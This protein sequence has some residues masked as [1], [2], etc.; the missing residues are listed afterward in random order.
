MAISVR[1]LIE[2]HR[3]N[4]C[5]TFDSL[6]TPFFYTLHRV[7]GNL[8][9]QAMGVME[10]HGFSPSE[11]DVLASLRRSPPPHEMTPSQLQQALLITSGGLTKILQQLEGRGLIAR[12]IAPGDRRVKPVH[13]TEA[14]FPV[15]EAAMREMVSQ[16]C[17]RVTTLLTAEEIQRMTEILAKLL[18]DGEGQEG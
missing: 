5:E 2:L 8:L 14:A 4:W 13:L 16:E 17:G 7:H 12:S 9:G 10:R 6:L 11:F 3:Q 15:V 1:E 18:V